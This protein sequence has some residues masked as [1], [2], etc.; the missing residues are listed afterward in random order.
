M[1]IPP[2][3]SFR[4]IELWESYIAAK[5]APFEKDTASYLKY[6]YVESRENS[7]AYPSQGLLTTPFDFLPNYQK[8]ML[9]LEKMTKILRIRQYFLEIF[10]HPE[11]VKYLK[12][13]DK[14]K[15]VTPPHLDSSVMEQAIAKGAASLSKI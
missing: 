1:K 3:A 12:L 14:Q 15:W 8:A 7:H 6:W 5:L 2:F 11:R 10:N 9:P 13:A 4:D